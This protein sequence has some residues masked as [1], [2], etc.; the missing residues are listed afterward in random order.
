MQAREG[1]HLALG[2]EARVKRIPR[3]DEAV[4]VWR[5]YSRRALRVP[6]DAPILGDG[7]DNVG[8]ALGGAEGES[9][10]ACRD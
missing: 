4:V 8:R 9:R 10:R 6:A 3:V 1:A 7:E 2:V 5:A